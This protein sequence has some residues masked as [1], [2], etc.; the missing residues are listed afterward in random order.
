MDYLYVAIIC[1][2][3]LALGEGIRWFCERQTYRLSASILFLNREIERYQDDG[4][5]S[6]LRGDR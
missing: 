1:A 2:L 5:A 3:I 4:E 6:E